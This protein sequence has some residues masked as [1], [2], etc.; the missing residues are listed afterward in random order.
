MSKSL[1]VFLKREMLGFKVRFYVT[2]LYNTKLCEKI[3]LHVFTLLLT[4][5]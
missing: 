1:A 5:K 3:S 4:L 2:K